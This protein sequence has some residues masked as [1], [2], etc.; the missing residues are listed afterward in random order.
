MAAL[1]G[2]IIM[3]SHNRKEEKERKR[4]ENDYLINLKGEL[5][6]RMPLQK[7]DS[8]LKEQIDELRNIKKKKMDELAILKSLNKSKV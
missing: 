8:L 4:A 2:P 6:I 7:I 3:I 1:Q 5:E